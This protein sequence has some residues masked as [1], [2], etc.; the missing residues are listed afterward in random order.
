MAL[1]CISGGVII[2]KIGVRLSL[3]MSGPADNPCRIYLIRPDFEYRGNLV[4]LQDVLQHFPRHPHVISYAGGLYLT[5]KNGTQ[6][7]LLLGVIVSGITDGLMYAVEGPIITGAYVIR[8]Q[9]MERATILFMPCWFQHILNPI[10]E[11][12]C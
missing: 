11:A 5:S 4:G 12:A 2:S 9:Y 8:L 1:F 6:W 10:A 7:L 3:I